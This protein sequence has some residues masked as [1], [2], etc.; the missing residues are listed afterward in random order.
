MKGREGEKGRKR[1]AGGPEAPLMSRARSLGNDHMCIE[2]SKEKHVIVL[3]RKHEA[4]AT[5]TKTNVVVSLR[6]FYVTHS[7]SH[8]NML[9]NFVFKTCAI[10]KQ[11]VLIVR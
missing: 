8:I 7:H 6:K 5:S 4:Y 1:E 2:V 10:A 3:I 11:Q 9:S